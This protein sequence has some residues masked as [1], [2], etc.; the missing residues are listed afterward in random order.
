MKWRENAVLKTGQEVLGF[1]NDHAAEVGPVNKSVERRVL[2]AAVAALDAAA[3]AQNAE[4]TAMTSLTKEKNARRQDLLGDH[5]RPVVAIAGKLTKTGTSLT[6]DIQTMRMP[7]RRTSDLGLRLKAL[8]MAKAVVK[9]TDQYVAQQM[10][11]D[12]AKQA[13]RAVNDLNSMLN[14]RDLSVMNHVRATGAAAQQTSI[15]REAIKVLN[16][17][18]DSRLR[19][20]GRLDL[21]EAWKV[22]KRYPQKPG[23]KRR[24]KKEE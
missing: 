20:I 11:P 7:K 21:V 2:E 18:V 14:A 4:K 9:Y 6:P 17:L 19:R 12:F 5:M 15:V 3:A 16:G 22:V 8:G 13:R 10:P 23:V 24:R 1:L